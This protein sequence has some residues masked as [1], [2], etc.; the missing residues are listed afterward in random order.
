MGSRTNTQARKRLSTPTQAAGETEQRDV[1]SKL[2]DFTR[3]MEDVVAENE[4]AR[5]ERTALKQSL[6]EAQVQCS[7]AKEEAAT[8]KERCDEELRTTKAKHDEQLRMQALDFEHT[9]QELMEEKNELQQ[10]L[11][12]SAR[13][14]ADMG[15]MRLAVASVKGQLKDYITLESAGASLLTTTGQVA[16]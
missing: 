4:E 3:I 11:E 10:K 6:T 15:H 7:L 12:A 2:S 5:Q 14:N 16:C 8:A 1:R 9:I 13:D